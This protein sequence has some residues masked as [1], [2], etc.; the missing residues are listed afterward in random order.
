MRQRFAGVREVG[1]LLGL[2]SASIYRYIQQ[3]RLPAVKI[4][5][6]WLLPIQ[7]LEK[8]LQAQDG[9]DER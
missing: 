2:S 1:E 5:G 8:I 3:K 9:K 4:H 6:K 7:E